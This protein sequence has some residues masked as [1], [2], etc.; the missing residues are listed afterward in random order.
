MNKSYHQHG[1]FA[2]ELAFVLFALCAI[3]LFASDL[4]HKLLIRAQ[5]DRTSFA[6]VNILKERTRY[7]SDYIGGE[8]VARHEINEND[9][10]DMKILAARM[11]NISQDDVAIK[12][13]SI[14]NNIEQPSFISQEFEDLACQPSRSIYDQRHL[15]PVEN[16]KSYP[17]YQVSICAKHDSWFL[18]FMRGQ[19]ETVTI[20][21]SSVI[22]G[23]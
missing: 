1:V 2:V 13:E 15:I 21:S 3:F 19:N 17:L 5:L 9:N 20:I 11:L 22:A 4:S 18:P 7:Y 8:L 6:L 10:I 12:L 14:I 16:T 23:R